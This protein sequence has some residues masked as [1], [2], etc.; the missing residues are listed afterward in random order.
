MISN[1][2]IVVFLHPAT[3]RFQ[4]TLYGNQYLA[5]WSYLK[6]RFRFRTIYAPDL[7]N[8]RQVKRLTLMMEHKQDHFN[9]DIRKKERETLQL[10]ERLS[11]KIMEKKTEKGLNCYSYFN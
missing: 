3:K 11:K 10:K 6:F 8:I 5:A 7:C 2:K 4:Y 1:F 9:H